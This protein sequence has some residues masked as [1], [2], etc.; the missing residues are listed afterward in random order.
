MH[1][2]LLAFKGK[3]RV[4][5]ISRDATPVRTLINAAIFRG[6]VGFSAG[7]PAHTFKRKDAKAIQGLLISI[8]MSSS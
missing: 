4:N 2:G 6:R 1:W 5:G 8:S 7:A 3:S